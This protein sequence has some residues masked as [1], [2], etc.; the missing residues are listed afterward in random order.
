MIDL[1]LSSDGKHAV[2]VSADSPEQLSSLAP[3][4]MRL[5][6]AVLKSYGNIAEMW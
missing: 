2:H 1:C 4:A 6:E 5:Y 3:H